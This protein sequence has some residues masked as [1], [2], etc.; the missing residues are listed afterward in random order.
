MS[1]ALLT[2]AE[3]LSLTGSE[4]NQAETD[5]PELVSEIVDAAGAAVGELWDTTRSTGHMARAAHILT[6]LGMSASG[7]AGVAGPI[8]AR[9]IAGL[10]V[11]YASSAFDSSDAGLSTTKWGRMYLDLRASVLSV[12]TTDVGVLI[13]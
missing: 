12:P 5:N 13:S 11:S 9:S 8:S 3:F 2:K 6:L 4:F 10:S 1:V 7:A